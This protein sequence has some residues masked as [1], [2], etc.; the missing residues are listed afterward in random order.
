MLA[1]SAR[2]PGPNVIENSG[3]EEGLA[4]WAWYVH[5]SHG[6]LAVVSSEYT[7]G[8]KGHAAKISVAQAGLYDSVELGQGRV[9]VR[10]G[11][12]YRLSFRARS[13]ARQPMRIQIVENAPPW[14]FYGFRVSTEITPEWKTYRLTGR[15]TLTG[16]DAKLLFQCGGAA[17][18]IWIDEVKLQEQRS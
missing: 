15:A 12:R 3:F 13:T 11:H 7:R 8:A 18:E 2:R 10:A 5:Q 4:N 9:A 16:T 6:A 17:G 1:A 14:T